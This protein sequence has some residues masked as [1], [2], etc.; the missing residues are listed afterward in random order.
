MKRSLAAC[1]ICGFPLLA[2]TGDNLSLA[3]RAR[4]YLSALIRLDTTNP[5]G[6][7]TLAAG[8]L[9][10]ITDSYRIPAELLGPDPKRLN[11][12]ARLRGDGSKRPLLLMAHTDVVPADRSQWT[13]D[14][15]SG[16]QRGG[17]IFGRGAIDAK[18][19]LAAHLAVLV[20]LRRRAIPLNRD[21]ILLAEADEESGSSGI[22]WM[23]ANAYSQIDAEFALNEGGYI[24]NTRRGRIFNVQTAEKIPTRLVLTARGSAAHGSLPRS[25]N[26]VVRLA[27][28]VTRLADADQPVRLNAVTR[29]YLSELSRIDD[30]TW[31]QSLLPRLENSATAV[32]AANQIRA[33]D[34]E[35]DAM[36]RSSFAPTM[37]RAGAKI[38]V[39]PNAAQA[40]IDVRRL[41]QETREEILARTRQ[42]VNDTSIEVAIA[43]GQQMPA[44]EPTSVKTALYQAIEHAAKRAGGE[45][46]LPFM[47]RGATD[48]SFLRA[49]GMP[50]YGLPLFAKETG[51][52]R[53]HGNDERISLPNLDDGV[54]TL[55]QIVMQVSAKH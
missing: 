31:L 28:A 35:I 44:T 25:D 21:I 18:S 16:E 11:F 40:H 1:L 17:F 33:R 12:V 13:A 22:Q 20:E 3:E 19:L 5:P 41:P 45:I 52:S 27:R 51:D 36:L 2:S 50:V 42:I 7:E 4:R 9:K 14:P 23:I 48:A 26:P 8:Y 32:A 34:P 24:L 46:V 43:P 53:A 29:R 38:N 49:R 10:Q 54:E 15:F 37:L 47:S 39:I 55:W 30:F 6:N